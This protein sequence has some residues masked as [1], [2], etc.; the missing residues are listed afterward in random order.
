MASTPIVLI[1]N[2]TREQNDYARAA[3]YSFD[4]DHRKVWTK[5]I[6]CAPE[7]LGQ[8]LAEEVTAAG[9]RGFSFY[10]MDPHPDNVIALAQVR[11]EQKE[12]AKAAGYRFNFDTKQWLK[13]FHRAFVDH[14]KALAEANGFS[15]NLVAQSDYAPLTSQP[16]PAR[17]GGGGRRG[18]GY[19]GYR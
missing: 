19:P 16:K 14:E 10:L 9:M 3:G 18:A 2:A 4:W 13:T 12:S 11:F 7:V 5:S 1:S 17:H 6:P 15:I 8:L